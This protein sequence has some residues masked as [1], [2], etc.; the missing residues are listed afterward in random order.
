MFLDNGANAVE[1][2]R[3]AKAAGFKAVEGGIPPANDITL[4]ELVRVQQETGL[5]QVLLNIATGEQERYDEQ[6]EYVKLFF[7]IS[8]R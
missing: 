4:E 1:R 2:Y 7:S 5:E 8:C 6:V 3:A